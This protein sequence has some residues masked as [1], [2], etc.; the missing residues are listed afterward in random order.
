MI[1]IQDE[2]IN[3]IQSLPFE[4]PS[5]VE[6]NSNNNNDA[7]KN[8]CIVLFSHTKTFSYSCSHYYLSHFAVA[9]T[10]ELSK[11]DIIIPILQMSWW[12]S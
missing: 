6:N 1:S 12:S 2:E 4:D 7:N 11:V 8:I 10:K 5:L 3:K 9:D